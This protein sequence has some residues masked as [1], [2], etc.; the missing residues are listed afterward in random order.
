MVSKRNEEKMSAGAQ[1]PVIETKTASWFSSKDSSTPLTPGPGTPKSGRKPPP[2]KGAEPATFIASSSTPPDSPGLAP[3]TTVRVG[4]APHGHHSFFN[5]SDTK[6]SSS[7]RR[8][9]SSQDPI[10]PSTKRERFTVMLDVALGSGGFGTVYKGFDELNGNYVAVK[11]GNLGVEINSSG[12]E[13]EFS[14]LTRLRHRNIVQVIDFGLSEKCAQIVMEWMSSGSVSATLKQTGFRLHENVVR[15]FARD[16][17][18]G[19]AYLHAEGVLH[20]DI[21]PA[22]M[23]LSEDGVLKLSDFG[24]SKMSPVDQSAQASTQNVVGT[25]AYLAPEVITKGRYSKGSDVW[26]LGCSLVEMANGAAPWSE[27][28]HEQQSA[29]PLM[30]HIGTAVPPSHHPAIPTHLSKALH[31]LVAECF[32]Y[33]AKDRASAEQLLADPYFRI[34]NLPEDAEPFEVYQERKQLKPGYEGDRRS[35]TFEVDSEDT[36]VASHVSVS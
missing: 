30:F 33:D 5:T 13:A 25:S 23:L 31:R 6:L 18:A 12:L 20:R 28:P 2:K 9:Q 21:K 27:L 22:N 34:T 35:L 14:L 36:T 15:K 24:T 1:K 29:I 17:L 26:A 4:K 10:V 3:T 7:T 19:L 11:R 8:V 32:K 16:A